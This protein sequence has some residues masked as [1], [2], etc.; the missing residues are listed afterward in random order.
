[1]RFSKTKIITFFIALLI[2]GWFL[3]PRELFLGF[4]YEG[5][6]ELERAEQ[7]YRNY[8]AK[9]SLNKFAT[10]RLANLYLRMGEP[11]NA[12]PLLRSL[13]E[14]RRRD[15]KVAL[16]YI[17]HLIDLHDEAAAYHLQI[18]VAKNFMEAP[19]HPRGKLKE[20]LDDALVYAIWRQKTKDCF[21]LIDLLLQV[22]R[23]Q[24]DYLAFK[25]DLER[26]LQ[27]TE[28]VLAFLG[29]RLAKDPRDNDARTELANIQAVL[30]KREEA[31]AILNEGLSIDPNNRELLDFRHVLRAKSGDKAGAITDL[32]KILEDKELYSTERAD[33]LGKLASLYYDTGQEEKL[34]QLY[35]DSF[36][37]KDLAAQ[38][39]LFFARQ[40][41][42][43]YRDRKQMEK[44]LQLYQEIWDEGSIPLEEKYDYVDKL[45]F[46]YGKR[47]EW[48]KGLG[49]YQRALA[50]PDLD[51]ELLDDLYEKIIFAFSR[52]RL[53]ERVVETYAAAVRDDRLLPSQA[54]DFVEG[55]A[56]FYNK[57]GKFDEVERVYREAMASPQL[58]A[59]QKADLVERLAAFYTKRSRFEEAIGLYRKALAEMELILED[60]LF[61]LEQLA[62]TYFKQKKYDEAA[63][64][65]QQGFGLEGL[66]SKDLANLIDQLGFVYAK[67]GEKER[68]L[69]LSLDYLNDPRLEAAEQSELARRIAEYYAKEKNPDQA[70]AY[71]QRALE[72]HPDEP[73]HWLNL[74]YFL[75]N[76]H[77]TE[78][79]IELLTNYLSYFPEDQDRRKLLVELYVYKAKATE[80]IPLYRAHVIANEDED[81]A[82]AVADLLARA[83][84]K[85]TLAGWLEEMIPRFPKTYTLLA[86]AIEVYVVRQEFEEAK[87]LCLKLLEEN[88]DNPFLLA[89]LG[90]LYNI[91][92]D[93]AASEGYYQ[94]L[95]DL[96]IED[97]RTLKQVGIDILFSGDAHR[98]LCYLKKAAAI[99]AKDSW[100]LFWLAEARYAQGEKRE[101]E[102]SSRQVIALLDKKKTLSEEEEKFLVKSRGRLHLNQAVH[103][104]YAVLM[105]QY[106]QNVDIRAD[107]LDLLIEAQDI[108][109]AENSYA[110]MLRRFP[111]RAEDL[112][113][114]EIRIAFAKGQWDKAVEL[115]LGVLEKR[116]YL[117]S[118]RRDL[119]W[120]YHNSGQ[121]QKAIAEYRK[122][123]KAGGDQSV[124][125]KALTELYK[126]YDHR[127][128]GQ[129]TLFDFGADDYQVWELAAQSFLTQKL[130][131]K[132]KSADGLF[133]AASDNFKDHAQF[134]KF[135]LGTHVPNGWS[136]EAGAGFGRS[137]L[138]NTPSGFLL[139][140]FNRPNRYGF[141]FGFDYREMRT[142]FPEAVSGGTLSDNVVLN[143][144]LHW[145]ERPYLFANSRLRRNYLTNGLESFE[146]FS[147]PGFSY[148]LFEKPEVHFGY[149]FTFQQV[150][151]DTGFLGLVPLIENYRTHL[152]S[153]SLTHRLGRDFLLTAAGFVGEDTARNTHLFQGDLYGYNAGLVWNLLRWLDLSGNY[154]FGK[155]ALPTIAGDSHQFGVALSGHWH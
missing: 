93:P 20:L 44:V 77:K 85:E 30:G 135:T 59:G 42:I 35:S 18:E 105:K 155:E 81:I 23:D 3:Y 92:E 33:T 140:R 101:G 139:A 88:P 104:S 122:V 65:Y 11:E 128:T 24:E 142:D 96:E 4:I 145:G 130:Q 37:S 70:Y 69:A 100:L 138:R 82:A 149:H 136:W 80:Q 129:Y 14:H 56:A 151:A 6:A 51:P 108:Q 49:L 90:H 32:Q 121:W 125:V 31:M 110:D 64:L 57:G 97:A 132:G 5:T 16:R 46:L 87:T 107:Y 71:Y 134:G 41:D 84:E 86:S 22:T 115:I 112:Q 117:V 7:F 54:I 75:E 45:A 40:I 78:E 98:S 109:K 68:A 53:P 150:Y 62:S 137:P 114:H 119:A 99:E 61:F 94:R 15:W 36:R 153:L 102:V 116:P 21:E 113:S 146:I 91:L 131:F 50:D 72:V 58:D 1:M 152:F 95:L 47:G 38:D 12:T 89:K 67:M 2:L 123:Q 8:L 143:G 133:N 103:D 124:A 154:A 79:A 39:R 13:Y 127:I 28:P 52:R 27:K 120:A 148:R 34:F 60:R 147:E 55:L 76:L 74:I 111:E 19:L 48:Q 26:G 43:F 141:S 25:A 83:G 29:T 73:D 66:A 126:L 9:R 118:Y 144:H 17:D 63:S 10:L 106:P